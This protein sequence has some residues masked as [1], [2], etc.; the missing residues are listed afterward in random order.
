LTCTNA[1][2]ASPHLITPVISEL[3]DAI[4]DADPG[5]RDHVLALIRLALDLKRGEK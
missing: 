5:W 2:T 3:L 4:T 1:E